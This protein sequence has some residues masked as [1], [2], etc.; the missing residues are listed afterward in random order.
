MTEVG[1]AK[2]VSEWKG[3]S[4][5]SL[6]T[7][8]R[9]GVETGAGTGTCL[10]GGEGSFGFLMW[11]RWHMYSLVDPLLPTRSVEPEP[12]TCPLTWFT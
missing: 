5:S 10:G 11:H 9:E 3:L 1:L 12:S 2:G 7:T 6:E 4:G 8:S